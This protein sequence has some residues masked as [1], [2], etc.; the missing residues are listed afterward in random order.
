MVTDADMQTELYN[1]RMRLKRE[2]QRA[3]Q[4]IIPSGKRKLAAEW[5]ET[6]GELFYKEL[7]SCAK[8]R[9][10]CREIADWKLDKFDQQRKR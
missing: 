5:R 6:Y 2:M 10:G 8:N 7:I 9:D 4:C 1:S 3:I